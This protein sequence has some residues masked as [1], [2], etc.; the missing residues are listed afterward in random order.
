MRKSAY[1]A[2]VVALGLSVSTAA[3]A[4]DGTATP[5]QAAPQVQSESAANS[6]QALPDQGNAP[7]GRTNSDYGTLEPGLADTVP[8]TN[9]PSTTRNAD[10]TETHLPLKGA[11]SFSQAEATRALQHAGYTQ[12]TGLAKDDQSVW[13]GTAMKGDQEVS[14]A[15]D[16]RG[17]I[18][19]QSK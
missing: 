16:Y 13:R 10:T 2:S 6:E 1:L 19:D 9:M 4:A 17:R 11:N 8:G 7:A 15:L 12:V 14:V 3:F 18:T 5:E